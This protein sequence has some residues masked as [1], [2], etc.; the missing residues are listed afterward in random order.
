MVD[1]IWMIHVDVESAVVDIVDVAVSVIGIAAV[2][3]IAEP[4]LLLF[5]YI[6]VI[7]NVAAVVGIT[8]DRYSSAEVLTCCCDFC[9]NG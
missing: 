9:M 4:S 7:T 5:V 3:E 2:A 1:S 8:A 6:V